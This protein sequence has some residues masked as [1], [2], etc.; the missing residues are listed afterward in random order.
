M[1]PPRFPGLHLH[2]F[3]FG[4]FLLLTALRL[5]AAGGWSLA[6]GFAGMAAVIVAA[7]SATTRWPGDGM[8]RLR[9][10]VLPM[11]VNV[12]YFMLGTVMARLGAGNCDPELL[13][14]DR[15]LFGETPAV[16]CG[17]WIHPW[18]TEVLSACYLSFL[19]AVLLAFAITVLRPGPAGVRLFD[20]LFGVYAIG[21]LGYTLVPAAGP[22]LAMPEA[23][24]TP[25]EG[26][27]LTRMN[28]AAIGSGSNHVDVFPSLHTAVTV[29]LMGW[30]W[31][32]KRRLFLALSLPAAGICMSTIY[33][34][35]HYAVDVAA[36]LAL[37]AAG[38]RLSSLTNKKHEL[39]PRFQ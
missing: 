38:L 24:A 18:L 25:L 8:A 34:R 33:L 2:E 5:F 27:F 28:A 30:L 37:A 6:L 21:F 32:R 3:L 23:F 10:A 16:L 22:H 1:K 19:P 13:C 15:L 7:A 26:G 36:G 11:L 39:D 9:L 17:A 4:G 12:V 31:P 35:Y 20:G 29:F 14:V